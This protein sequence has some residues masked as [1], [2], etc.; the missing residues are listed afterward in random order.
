VKSLDKR[1]NT[2]AKIWKIENGRIEQVKIKLFDKEYLC[3]IIEPEKPLLQSNVKCDFCHSHDVI[4]YGKK[5]VKNKTV[6]LYMCKACRRRFQGS[7]SSLYRY[8]ED[9]V[10]R[11][12]ELY[13]Q[14]LS[15]R[16]ISKK[17]HDEFKIKVS[18]GTVLQWA[19][20]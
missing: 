2:S 18:H 16:K 17:I 20:K 12:K 11:A 15:S 13:K 14:R 5:Y 4:K 9:L 8:N 10:I 19:K 3:Q 1:F 7:Y 6:Q